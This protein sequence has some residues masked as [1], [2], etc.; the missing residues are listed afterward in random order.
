MGGYSNSDD[1]PLSKCGQEYSGIFF[2]VAKLDE[3]FFLQVNNSYY[4]EMLSIDKNSTEIEIK[5]GYRKQALR[6][7]SFILYI[8][9]NLQQYERRSALAQD[10]HENE[11]KEHMRPALT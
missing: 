9:S 11:M 8:R 10:C 1:F 3:M 7:C 4:Y 2:G 5:K 6:C